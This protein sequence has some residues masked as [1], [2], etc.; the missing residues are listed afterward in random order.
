LKGSRGVLSGD[1]GEGEDERKT[2][3]YSLEGL[4]RT[5]LFAVLPQ[6]PVKEEAIIQMRITVDPDGNIIR[7]IPVRKGNPAL[8]NAVRE[9]LRK[10]KFNALPPGVPRENQTGIITFRFTLD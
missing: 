7:M 1:E 2:S 5:P 3:P 6:Y 8:E 10:W 9:A 4:N